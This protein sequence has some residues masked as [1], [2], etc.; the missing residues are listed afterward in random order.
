MLEKELERKVRVECKKR[1][2]L[3]FKWVSPGEVGVPDRVCIFPGGR[4][5]F[6]ELKRP[7]RKDGLSPRQRKIIRLLRSLGCEAWVINDLTEFIRRLE[8]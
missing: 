5:I 7:G 8:E 4:V 3:C 1:G 6:L 2:G